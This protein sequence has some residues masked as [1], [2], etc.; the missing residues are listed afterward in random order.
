VLSFALRWRRGED[1]SG[2]AGRTDRFGSSANEFGPETVLE[3]A[4]RYE[5]TRC[6]GPKE[7]E[8]P[9][10]PRWRETVGDGRWG[11]PGMVYC[12]S[13]GGVEVIGAKTSH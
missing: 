3:F 2:E 5:S 6:C 8:D 9:I 7:N 1:R 11:M 12:P 10:D 4:S 13:G